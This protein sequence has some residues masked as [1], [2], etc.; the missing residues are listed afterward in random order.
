LFSHKTP[1]LVYTSI[2]KESEENL[3][4]CEIAFDGNEINQILEDLYQRK[5]QSL[6]VEG[7]PEILNSF[8]SSN[9]WDEAHVFVGRK[10]F[11]QGVPAPKI[12][13]TP[14]TA[15]DLEGTS[16]YGYRN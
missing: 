11:H 1:T 14:M 2:K 13:G 15:D 12:T 4:Y 9:L 7:G 3:S 5:I 6:I 16:L 10:L 8:I